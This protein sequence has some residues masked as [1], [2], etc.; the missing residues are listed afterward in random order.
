MD[1][2]LLNFGIGDEMFEYRTL[3]RLGIATYE[4]PRSRQLLRGDDGPDAFAR[5]A[6]ARACGI[7]RRYSY[8]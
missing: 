2:D 6:P 8:L 4:R 3:V 1:L 7:C 5:V